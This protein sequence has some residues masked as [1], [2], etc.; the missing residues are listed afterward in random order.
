MTSH[1]GRQRAACS[2]GDWLHRQPEPKEYPLRKSRR[3]R[4]VPVLA[5]SAGLGLVLPWS[6][7]ACVITPSG[8]CHSHWMP[9]HTRSQLIHDDC[10]CLLDGQARAAPIRRAMEL[11]DQ[12]LALPPPL[13]AD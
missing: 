6:K 9:L 3:L 4:F 1:P 11:G 7:G 8:A 2:R 13:V 5:R 10:K 12:C